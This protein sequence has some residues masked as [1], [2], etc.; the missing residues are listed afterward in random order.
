MTTMP[1]QW[2]QQRQLKDSNNTLTTRATTQSQMKANHAIITKTTTPA[3]WQQGCLRID[4]G[5][6]TIVTRATIA[7]T[8]IAKTPVHWQQQCHHDKDNNTS[9][10][11]SNEG[12]DASSTTIE[13]PAHWQQQQCIMT[14]ATIAIATRAK[15]PAHQW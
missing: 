8:T 3:Q 6:D 14:R 5:N 15:M 9:L 1:L 12:N 7:I 2:G 4:N 10:M 11:M 13:M